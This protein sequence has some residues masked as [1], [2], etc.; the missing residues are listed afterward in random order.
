LT[1]QLSLYDKYIISPLKDILLAANGE[2]NCPAAQCVLGHLCLQGNR[3][4]SKNVKQAIDY[5]EQSSNQNFALAQLT[6][7]MM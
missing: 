3:L 7:G 1:L 5:L 2:M 6:L 4:V